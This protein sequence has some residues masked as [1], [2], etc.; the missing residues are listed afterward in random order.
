MA[1]TIPQRRRLL[2]RILAKVQTGQL[3]PDDVLTKLL[4]AIGARL[5]DELTAE[6]LRWRADLE[7]AKAAALAQVAQIDADLP[8]VGA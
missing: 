1:L 8:D 6:A 4:G 7:A 2:A 3:D 5:D